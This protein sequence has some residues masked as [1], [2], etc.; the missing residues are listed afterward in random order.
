MF[1]S[2]HLVV[3][4]DPAAP[5]SAHKIA[6]VYFMMAI[7]VMFDLNR[8]P[9]RC[10]AG[11]GLTVA[12]PRAEELFALGRACLNAIGLEHASPATV[13]ALHLCGT[14]VLNE[15]GGD[16]G[17]TFWPILGIAVKVAQSVSASVFY[18]ADCSL[19]YIEMALLLGFPPTR[20]LRGGKCGGRSS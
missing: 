16:G 3:A 4:Y 19:V 6:C 17:E 10:F 20:S 11:S 1:D 14:F 18:C 2:D 9:G 5:I 8:P 13:Q 12:D 7:G 15:K